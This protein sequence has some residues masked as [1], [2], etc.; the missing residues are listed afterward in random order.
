MGT[1]E[2]ATE[3]NTQDLME[4]QATPKTEEISIQVNEKEINQ[5]QV[6][7]DSL[8]AMDPGA[9]KQYLGE[10][11]YPLI[12]VVPSLICRKNKLKAYC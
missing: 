1:L 4:T 8:A 9:R 12:K 11:L 7:M 6:L 2:T 5:K 10:M 3:N